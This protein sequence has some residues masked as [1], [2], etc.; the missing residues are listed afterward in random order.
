MPTNPVNKPFNYVPHQKGH[1]SKKTCRNYVRP[2]T[3]PVFTGQSNILLSLTLKG[4]KSRAIEHT[5]V[6]CVPI[7][8]FFK[9]WVADGI[10]T[11][12]T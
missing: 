4:H 8:S 5:F 11:G 2:S 10:F 7:M 1:N 12:L 9:K 6:L 3:T